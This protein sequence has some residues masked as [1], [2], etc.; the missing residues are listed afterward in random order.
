MSSSHG[1]FQD[2]SE[3]Q[4]SARHVLRLQETLVPPAQKDKSR[5]VSLICGSYNLTKA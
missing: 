2:E 5:V 1:Y 3:D 4:D